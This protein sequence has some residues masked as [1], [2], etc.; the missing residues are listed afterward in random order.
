MATNKPKIHIK[1]SKR[2]SLRKAMGAKEGKKLSVSAMRSRLKNASPAM[3]KKLQ[4]ALNARK[5]N[6]EFGGELP[7]F[8]EGGFVPQIASIDNLTGSFSKMN[9]LP[10]EQLLP[11]G[12]APY[13]GTVSGS[14]FSLDPLSKGIELYQNIAGAALDP[15]VASSQMEQQSLYA[16]AGKNLRSVDPNSMAKKG[17]WQGVGSNVAKLGPFAFLTSLSNRKKA[18]D[19]AELFNKNIEEQIFN[20]NV[21]SR[22]STMQQN[23][24]YMPVAKQGGFTVYKGQT[25]EGPDGGI[26][27]DEFGN[28]SGLSLNKPIALT[29]KNE[30]ARYNPS[31]R[32]TYI[33][34]DSL[35][36]SKPATR[37]VNKFKLNKQGSLYKHDPLIKAAVDKQFDNLTTA[38]EFAKGNIIPDETQMAEFGGM[39]KKGGSLTASKAKEMLKDG[40]AHGKK[41]TPKQ[42]RYFGW[43]AGGKKEEGGYIDLKRKR[44]KFPFLPIP[45]APEGAYTHSAVDGTLIAKYGGELPMYQDLGYL[46]TDEDPILNN[47]NY[48]LPLQTRGFSTNPYQID[49][50]ANVN[51]PISNFNGSESSNSTNFSDPMPPFSLTNPSKYNKW[52]EWNKARRASMRS[53]AIPKGERW[54]PFQNENMRANG[55]GIGVPVTVGRGTYGNIADWES[56]R[57]EQDI[58][59]NIYKGEWESV[60]DDV[61]PIVKSGTGTGHGLRPIIAAPSEGSVAHIKPQYVKRQ[62]IDEIL[63]KSPLAKAPISR[64]TPDTDEANPILNP[65]GHL[66]AGASGFLDYNRLKKAA[67]EPVRLQRAA[68]E[69]ISLAK[70]RLANIRNAE[71]AKS[72][73]SANARAMGLNAGQAAS[74]MATTTTGANRLL[75]QQNAELLEREETTNAQMQQQANIL[76]AELAAQESL[77]NT[78]QN[79]AYRMML[80]SN[81]PWSRALNTAA[82]YFKDNASYQRSYDTAKLYAPNAEFYRDPEASKL[83][84]LMNTGKGKIKLRFKD[85]K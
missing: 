6:H 26:L 59:A 74:N 67:P 81:D 57:N 70:Q 48:K 25:H 37:L 46:P 77:F 49:F 45:E 44:G 4:F 16:N 47:L 11:S 28:P 85:K 15:L 22:L 68:A 43:V 76:N 9:N 10:G 84:K 72:V 64:I 31:T 34:S 36:F 51:R 63:N 23:P 35:G 19:E 20:N 61:K 42:M 71:A 58:T 53:T 13:S 78:Q 24:N 38:Q 30:V 62:T 83:G 73:G 65:L 7:I 3:K 56:S 52:R 41:L 60:R 18:K 5:W 80:A 29:E 75:G 55:V 82:S 1:P 50:S 21:S 14:G 66:L 8:P 79:N 12:L 39:L 69:R 17:Y 33:Y 32:S 27:T 54:D 2:G 40:T